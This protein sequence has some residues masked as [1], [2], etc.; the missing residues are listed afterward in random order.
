MKKETTDAR[1]TILINK[2]IEKETEVKVDK[3]LEL[4]NL[5]KDNSLEMMV[6]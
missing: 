1:A 2:D 4:P 5:K 6:V 3:M